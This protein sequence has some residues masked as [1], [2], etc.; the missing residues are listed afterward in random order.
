MTDPLGIA[1]PTLRR[2]PLYLGLF[3]ERRLAGDAWLSSETMARL[4]GSTAIQIRKDL[5]AIGAP[6][7]PRRGFPVTETAD[8]LRS[9]LHDDASIPVFLVGSGSLAEAVINDPSLA[10]HGFEI[11]AV[12]HPDPESQAPASR[13]CGRSIVPLSKLPDL[14]RRMGVHLALMAPEDEWSREAAEAV[15]A[16][17][18]TGVLDYTGAAVSLP[19][20]IVIVRESF[21]S[22]LARVLGETRRRETAAKQAPARYDT[23]VLNSR[24]ENKFEP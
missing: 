2:L 13:I 6:G 16:S 1:L 9:I 3:D 22:S 19:P 5:A 24:M 14:S 20:S 23:A 10:S 18:I 4:L 8:R 11:V 12:F 15:T 21:G 7:L 17:A